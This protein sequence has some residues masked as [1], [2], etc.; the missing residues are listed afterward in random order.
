[1]LANSLFRNFA[2]FRYLALWAVRQVGR[3]YRWLS[4]EW[5]LPL[6]WLVIIVLSAWLAEIFGELLPF[7][8][9]DTGLD[10]GRVLAFQSWWKA[11]SLYAL[12]VLLWWAWQARKRVVIEQF[13]DETKD[14][15]NTIAS[16]LNTLLLVELARLRDLYDVTVEDEQQAI[17]SMIGGSGKPVRA[18]IAVED[19]SDV[20]QICTA[21][22]WVDA[23]EVELLETTMGSVEPDLSEGLVLRELPRTQKGV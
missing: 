13:R 6:V 4:T 15:S 2:T 5:R 17:P 10:L 7:L 14:R 12:L 18:T 20:L 9:R 8:G 19:V 23:R 16:G 1:M 11:L 22:V 3:P 21:R